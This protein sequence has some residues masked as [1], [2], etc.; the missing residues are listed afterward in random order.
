MK[1]REC[2][3]NGWHLLYLDWDKEYLMDGQ[4]CVCGQTRWSEGLRRLLPACHWDKKE[5]GMNIDSQWNTEAELAFIQTI[6]THRERSV[7]TP[8]LV[9]LQRYLEAM[10]LRADWSKIDQG[11]VMRHVKAEIRKEQQRASKREG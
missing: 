5:E 10:P 6:G 2:R 8:R 9:W 7:K 1:G 11:V 3:G 4:G